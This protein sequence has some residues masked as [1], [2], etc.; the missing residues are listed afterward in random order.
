MSKA[1]ELIKS[2]SG[3]EVCLSSG[4]VVRVVPF[5]A[6]LWERIN[7]KALKQFPE[8]IPPKKTIKV[9]DGTEEVDDLSN[10]EYLT[11]KS[12]SESARSNLLGEAVIDLCI[13]LSLTEWEEQIKRM[14][15]YTEPYPPDPEDRRVRFLTD[16]ALRSKGDYEKIMVSAITQMAIGDK[17]IGERLSNFR[18]EM[19]RATDNGSTPSG[20]TE[21]VRLDI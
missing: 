18:S 19:A 10:P 13:K 9:V 5:P 4:V 17:D 21:V 14:E 1:R 2:E 12:E 16:Y 8:P 6:G 11:A 3:E 7:E 15:K 20:A